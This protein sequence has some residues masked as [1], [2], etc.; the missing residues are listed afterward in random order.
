[1]RYLWNK[2]CKSFSPKKQRDWEGKS[3]P[4]KKSGPIKYRVQKEGEGR[5]KD[6]GGRIKEGFIHARGGGVESI[7]LKQD[8]WEKEW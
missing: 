2:N 5:P 3:K 1:M 6:L 8:K 7:I 4:V